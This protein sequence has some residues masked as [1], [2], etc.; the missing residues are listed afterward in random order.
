MVLSQK[1]AVIAGL[2]VLDR[3]LAPAGAAAAVQHTPE[4][5]RVPEPPAAQESHA[6][7]DDAAPAFILEVADNDARRYRDPDAGL[8]AGFYSDGRVRVATVQGKR[9]SGILVNEKAVMADLHA[10]VSFEM[11]VAHSGN[12]V[13]LNMDGGPYDGSQIRLESFA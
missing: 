7:A 13:T 1:A 8:F 2:T 9:Y 5:A 12:S 10:D 11:L 4:P 6:A 3:L